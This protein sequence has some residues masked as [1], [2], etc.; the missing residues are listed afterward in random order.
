MPGWRGLA[1]ARVTLFGTVKRVP[2]ELQDVARGLFKR[3]HAE[4]TA[5]YGTSEF[6]LYMLSDIQDVYYVGGYGTVKWINAVD[7]LSCNADK[8]CDRRYCD[9][10]ETLNELNEEYRKKIPVLFSDAIKGK[11]ISIDRNGMDIRVKVKT[12]GH[13][14]IQRVRFHNEANSLE[15]A[16][17]E[18]DNI[19]KNGFKSRYP[20]AR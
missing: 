2:D 19:L 13:Y 14:V 4:E 17:R 1:S 7:Y 8:V 9:P 3:K 16:K 20:I 18:F 11:I 5:S 12:D 6:P 15:D 10:L